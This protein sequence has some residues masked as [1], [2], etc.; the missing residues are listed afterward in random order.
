MDWTLLLAFVGTFAVGIYL[1]YKI[2]DWILHSAVRELMNEAGIGEEEI[3][4]YIESIK[5]GVPQESVDNQPPK[6]QIR[7]EQVGNSI[8]C[9]EKNSD[10]FLGQAATREELEDVLTERLGPMTLLVEPE[11]GAD[12]LQKGVA[13]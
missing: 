4:T 12:L 11:D 3:D 9:Y 13:Q 1:G 10:R 7:L 5:N 2:S 6:L 8:F